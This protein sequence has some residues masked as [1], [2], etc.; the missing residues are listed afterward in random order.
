MAQGGSELAL[1]LAKLTSISEV[2]FHQ[3]DCIAAASTFARAAFEWGQLGV[4]YRIN[5]VVMS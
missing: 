1:G 5:P 2:R 4:P 3:S